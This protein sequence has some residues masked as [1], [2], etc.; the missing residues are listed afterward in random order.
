MISS[1]LLLNCFHII[2][3]LE[4]RFVASKDT[5]FFET[6]VFTKFRNNDMILRQYRFLSIPLQFVMKSSRKR[7]IGDIKLT[8]TRRIFKLFDLRLQCSKIDEN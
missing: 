7:K 4:R 6:G 1:F 8:A 3:H 2:T 5:N